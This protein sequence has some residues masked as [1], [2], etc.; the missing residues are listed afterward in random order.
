VKILSEANT[1]SYFGAALEIKE[2]ATVL[3]I[4]IS[5]MQKQNK[6]ECFFLPLQWFKGLSNGCE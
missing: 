6:L 3:I 5:L 1:L 4:F 2:N